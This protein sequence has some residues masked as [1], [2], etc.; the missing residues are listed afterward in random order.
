MCSYGTFQPGYNNREGKGAIKTR[1]RW[2]HLNL[3]RS[4]SRSPRLRSRLTG[5]ARFSYEHIGI[6]TKEIVG[7]RGLAQ[8]GQPGQPGSY[9]EALS[10]SV[11]D[12]KILLVLFHWRYRR[13]LPSWCLSS[14]M[15]VVS[16]AQPP[17]YYMLHTSLIC[18]YCMYPTPTC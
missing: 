18:M 14:L 3:F 10:K 17:Y 15:L 13:C 12:W 4:R 11:N 16:S 6:F 2:R 5:L 7:G 8:P 1:M 9:Q